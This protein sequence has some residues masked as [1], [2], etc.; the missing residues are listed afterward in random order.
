MA[1][2]IMPR[3]RQADPERLNA[4][5]RGSVSQWIGE[6]GFKAEELADRIGMPRSSFYKRL[7]EPETFR[8]DELRQLRTVIGEI[9][10]LFTE[11]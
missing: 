8:L 2:R 4:L 10:G 7:K 6:T 11:E 5:I 3:K 1:R 9:R